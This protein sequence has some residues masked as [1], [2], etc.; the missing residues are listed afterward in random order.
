M[1]KWCIEH[2]EE[3]QKLGECSMVHQNLA[4]YTCC[5]VLDQLCCLT[6]PLR[7]VSPWL[8]LP[9]AFP[10]YAWVSGYELF[11]SINRVYLRTLWVFFSFEQ[12]ARLFKYTH[13][14]A[15]LIAC[16][17]CI[18]SASEDL[19]SAY[20]ESLK[21]ASS[22]FKQIPISLELHCEALVSFFRPQSVLF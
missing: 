15:N 7:K 18:L 8:V 4:A 17:W 13:E 11:L 1:V 9:E 5:H 6:S 10:L 20:W 12:M 19:H 14:T 16:H 21:G 22:A 2:C 3:R